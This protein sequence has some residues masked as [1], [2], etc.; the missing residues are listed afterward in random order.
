MKKLCISP[1]EFVRHSWRSLFRATR[2]R[3]DRFLAYNI[4]SFN[5]GGGGWN[6]LLLKASI[7]N[8]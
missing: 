8:A 3:H 4:S 1:F 6:E 2:R 7:Q 5:F